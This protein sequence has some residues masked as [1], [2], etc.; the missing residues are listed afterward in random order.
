LLAAGF[1]DRVHGVTPLVIVA[2][3]FTG[4]VARALK[5]PRAEAGCA[6]A[7]CCPSRKTAESLK[8]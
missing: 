7:A 1:Y 8:L 3:P 4:P 2:L 5:E 6:L